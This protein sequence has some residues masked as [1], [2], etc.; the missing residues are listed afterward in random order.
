MAC[1]CAAKYVLLFY[2]ALSLVQLGVSITLLVFG[3]RGQSLLEREGAGPGIPYF[4][5]ALL[6]GTVFIITSLCSLAMVILWLVNYDTVKA[7]QRMSMV[8]CVFVYLGLPCTI[9]GLI[10]T[11]AF[12]LSNC[13]QDSGAQNYDQTGF[14]SYEKNIDEN[15]NTAVVILV[16]ILLLFVTFVIDVFML[17]KYGDLQDDTLEQG[18]LESGVAQ[19]APGSSGNKNKI[20]KKMQQDRERRNDIQRQIRMGVPPNR[21]VPKYFKKI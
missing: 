2:T 7:G 6:T 21:V 12:G 8:F 1:D 3:A 20:L 19:G 18:T 5:G 17:C 13:K 9:L 11:A 4:V 10:F 14:C 16:L 15:Y